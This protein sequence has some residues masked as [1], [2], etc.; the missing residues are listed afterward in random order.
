MAIEYGG[1]LRWSNM[2]MEDIWFIGDFPIETRILGG[3]PIATFDY[4]RVSWN[5]GTPVAGWFRMEILR[6]KWMRTGG[7][8]ISGN[9]HITSHEMMESGRWFPH[10]EIA[11]LR[12]HVGF[13]RLTYIHRY[14]HIYIYHSG[15]HLNGWYCWVWLSDRHWLCFSWISLDFPH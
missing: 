10:L 4:R 14:I 7:A 11:V 15:W 13:Q 1:T 12:F 5:G 2:E 3:F 8:P 9:L 6:K